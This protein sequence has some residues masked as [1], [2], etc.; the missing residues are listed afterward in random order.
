MRSVSDFVIPDSLVQGPTECMGSARAVWKRFS[1]AEAF[2]R[3]RLAVLP[4]GMKITVLGAGTVGTAVAV[5][6]A[7]SSETAHVQV[8]EAQPATLR[9]FRAAH[10]YPG[11]RTYEADARDAQALEPI[12]NG[13]TCVVSCVGPEHSPRLARLALDLGA[14][15]VDLGNPLP[16]PALAEHA[17]RR[18]RWVVTGC[19]LAPGLVG[20]LA[21]RAVGAMDEAR[22]VR[23]RVGDVP[24]EP[25]EP[26]RHRLAHSAERL[27][28]DYTEP[29]PVLVDGKIE[30][31]EPMTGV[32]SVEV[33]G[34]GTM[35]AFY[36]GAGLGSLAEALEGRVASLDVKTIRHPGHA[37]RMRFVLDLGLAERTSL[38]VRTHL[39]YRDVL[40]RRLRKRLGGDY[41]DAVLL[42]IEVDGTR[43]GAEGTLVY[44]M[45]DRCDP[46]TGLSAMQRCTGFPAATAAVLLAARALPGGGVGPADQVLPIEPFMDRL[47]ARGIAVHERWEAA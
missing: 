15:F 32:E 9:T 26:F 1:G 21:M 23:I 29:A 20:V 24:Q 37:E 33:D 30:T 40:V 18:Q 35:E 43:D 22:A 17:E 6:L 28:D 3:R 5:D 42:R 39:T 44:E 47:A 25:R 19:G 8:C 10:T 27:L 11:L 13:S 34:F 41:D 4:W 45:A 14:H 31:R 16:D 36:T 38:D 46:E 7:R 12:L 2:S